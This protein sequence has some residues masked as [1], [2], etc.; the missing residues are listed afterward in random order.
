MGRKRTRDFDLPPH[1][2]RK[3]DAFYYVTTSRPRKWIPLGGDLSVA[4]R[5]WAELECAEPVSAMTFGDAAKLYEQKCMPLKAPRTRKQNEGELKNLRLVFSEVALDAIRPAH[6]R[7]YLDTRPAKVRA[8]R[9]IALF[10]HLFNWSRERGYTDAPNP[11]YGVARNVERARDIYVEDEAYAAVYAKA[12]PELKDAMDL[13][14]YTGQRVSDV[15]KW[16]RSDIRDGALHVQQGKTGKKLRIKI[17]GPLSSVIERLKAPREGVTSLYL[18]Q[19]GGK[20]LT[21]KMLNDRFN[22]ACT[23]AKENYQF[24]DLRAKAATDSGGLEAAQKLLGHQ[25]VTMTE[26]YTRQ[27]KGEIVTPVTKEL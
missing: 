8:N 27:R 24:R 7:Q 15:L 18:V 25:S 9:E 10:S 5:K 14:Y 19:T 4:K 3:G 11:A 20:A 13:A 22:A 6:I 23:A 21:Y 2:A 26:D 17:A 16:T 12:V 1:M